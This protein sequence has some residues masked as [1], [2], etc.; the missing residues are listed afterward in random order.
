MTAARTG[1]AELVRALLDND[2]DV[3]ASVH[4]SRSDSAHVGG[5]RKDTRTS[6]ACS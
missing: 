3:N 1:S 6:W 4:F 5:R 2:A